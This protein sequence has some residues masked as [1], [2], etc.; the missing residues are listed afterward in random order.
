VQR[1]KFPTFSLAMLGLIGFLLG[2]SVYFFDRLAGSWGLAELSLSKNIHVLNVFGD[3]GYNLP[4]FSHAFALSLLTVAAGGYLLKGARV[5]CLG[6]LAVHFIFELG[7]HSAVSASLADLIRQIGNYRI[8]ERSALYFERGV[9]D[10]LDLVAS[11][12]GVSLAYGVIHTVLSRQQNGLH[13][14]RTNQPLSFI[15]LGRNK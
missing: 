7:Q 14:V 5:I 1:I 10:P 11:L 9:F 3:L 12:I 13:N 2:S 8:V 6:W 4:S 15:G